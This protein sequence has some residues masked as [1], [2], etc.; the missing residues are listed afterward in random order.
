METRKTK[1]RLLKRRLFR[2]VFGFFSLSGM[3]FIFQACYGTPQ[4][5]GSDVLVQGHV[6]SA[7]NN[8]AIDGIKVSVDGLP[9]YTTSAQDGSFNMYCPRQASY[10]FVFTDIDGEA[11]GVYVQKDTLIS[12]SSQESDIY[13][14]IKLD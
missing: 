3:L 5:F 6:V 10:S 8:Q 7:E 11:N 2:S 14:D 9:Q 13:L 1:R 4:D 12:L